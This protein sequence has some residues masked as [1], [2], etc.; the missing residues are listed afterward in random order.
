MRG[1]TKYHVKLACG[2]DGVTW[3]KMDPVDSP[4]TCGHCA[5][6]A[7]DSRRARRMVVDSEEA[8]V[9]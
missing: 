7:E 3:A 8:P 2:H 5:L 1:R 6:H 9:R 4:L